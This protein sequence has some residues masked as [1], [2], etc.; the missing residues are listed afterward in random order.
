MLTWPKKK[1][2]F[3]APAHGSPTFRSTLGAGGNLR[4]TINP[5]LADLKT[6]SVPPEDLDWMEREFLGFNHEMGYPEH[7]QRVQPASPAA[8]TRAVP[9]WEYTRRFRRTQKPLA[10]LIAAVT[11][12]AP[13]EERE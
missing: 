1:E 9:K 12:K 2:D 4:A 10:K 11:G 13:G 5:K 8:P 3:A 6:K 7:A